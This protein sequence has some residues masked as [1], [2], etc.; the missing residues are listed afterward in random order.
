[1]LETVVE[2]H[3][4]EDEN[5]N[6]MRRDSSFVYR[7]RELDDESSL[8]NIEA[9]VAQT[10]DNIPCL[11]PL[12]SD[13]WEDFDYRDELVD[14]NADMMENLTLVDHEDSS[15]KRGRISSKYHTVCEMGESL[16]H[17][18]SSANDDKK[19]T[20]TATV[21]ANEALKQKEKKKS[22]KRHRRTSTHVD[23]DQVFQ[24]L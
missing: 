14:N 5:N 6:T 16:T 2:E 23:F 9:F 19:K 13:S 3:P 24:S 20:S 7:R 21:D 11:S 8:K 12:D 22:C 1:M 4:N 15:S 18:L 17:P 10:V